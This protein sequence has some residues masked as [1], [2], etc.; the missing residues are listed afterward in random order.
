M[1]QEA[2]NLLS[3]TLE[4]LMPFIYLLI[5]GIVLSI[6]FS[7]VEMFSIDRVLKLVRGRRAFVFLGKDAY[8]GRLEIPPRSKGGFEVFYMDTA[9]ENPL[10]LVAFLIENYHETGNEKFLEKAKVLMSY[11][12]EKG[13]IS[14]EL[15][16]KDVKINPWAPPSMVSRKVYSNE[17]GDLWMIVS[18]VDFMSDDEK[19]RRWKEL[20]GLYSKPFLKRMKRRVYNALTY[21]KDKVASALTSTASTLTPVIPADLKKPLDEAEKKIITSVIAQSYD[22]LLENS[23]GRLVT[24]RVDDVEGERKLYQGVLGEYS[25]KYIYVLDVDYRLQM[26]AEV[27]EGEISKAYPIVKVFGKTMDLGKH[28]SLRWEGGLTVRNVWDRPIKVERIVHGENEVTVN[29]VLFPSEE[30]R[31]ER[32]IPKDFTLYYEISLES[33]VVWP[34]SKAVVIGLGDYPPRILGSVIEG[35]KVKD[36]VKK[37]I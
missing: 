26:V 37:V 34:R 17:L 30:I 10:S 8:Y 15:S 5:L 32:E 21:V 3:S 29:K 12:K 9:I 2:S 27:K 16:E 24:V 11:M 20:T 6:I 13:V 36:L 25:D 31:I 33:D 19:A 1:I 35:L 28:L 22:P 18:F 23:I 14:P 7:L 4:P